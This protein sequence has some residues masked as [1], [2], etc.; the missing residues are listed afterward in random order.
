MN[1]LMNST[2]LLIVFLA[3]TLLISSWG[4]RDNSFIEKVDIQLSSDDEQ[5]TIIDATY[6][7]DVLF[8][9]LGRNVDLNFTLSTD[10]LLRIEKVL[11]EDPFIDYARVFN[12]HDGALIMQLELKQPIARV[13][14]ASGKNYYITNTGDIAPFSYSYSP[15]VVVLTGAVPEI[16]SVS[17]LALV[18][19]L[20]RIHEDE[21]LKAQVESIH[22]KT[23]GNIYLIPKLG[24][25][26]LRYGQLEDA[27][28]KIKK[29]K[30]FYKETF[31]K[32]DWNEFDEVILDYKK[33]IVLKNIKN[34]A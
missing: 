30:S 31:D 15:R 27:D 33:Q 21:F 2:I 17:W 1:K 20:Q 22:I 25:F 24:N 28:E 10:E 6:V 5:P 11:L 23:D 14:D 32:L 13:I 9:K 12:N 8:K 16:Q 3:F 7:K 18:E 34:R 4:L 26:K 29:L 19:L